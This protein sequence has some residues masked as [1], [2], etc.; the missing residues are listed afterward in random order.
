MQLSTKKF[1]R[2]FS[3]NFHTSKRKGKQS[4]LT[5]INQNGAPGVTGRADGS[6]GSLS[7]GFSIT[8]F[9]AGFHE[10]SGIS[11]N[12]PIVPRIFREFPGISRNFRGFPG[13]S[14]KFPGNSREFPEF[15]EST[16]YDFLYQCPSHMAVNENFLINYINFLAK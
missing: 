3:E 2:K 12:F 1:S 11:P 7:F 16:E 8:V 10:T 13:K 6:M 9:F 14:R 4:F 15:L 5:I